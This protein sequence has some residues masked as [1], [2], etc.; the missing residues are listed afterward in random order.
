MKDMLRASE[1]LIWGGKKKMVENL[2]KS[3]YN[4]LSFSGIFQTTEQIQYV[5]MGSL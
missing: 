3:W 4:S 5:R 1:R 2:G